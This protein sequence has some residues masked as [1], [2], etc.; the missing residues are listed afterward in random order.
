MNWRLKKDAHELLNVKFCHYF[1]NS[2]VC[3]FEEKAAHSNMLIQK[4][5]NFKNNAKLTF[6]SLG[7]LALI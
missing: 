4:N 6:A 7:I 2:K 1:N 5:V 3:H